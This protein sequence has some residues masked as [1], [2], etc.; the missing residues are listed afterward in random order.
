[1][2]SQRYDIVRK[3][4]GKLLLID[5]AADL[6]SAK[7]RIKE[8]TS[9]WPGEFQVLDQQNHRTIAKNTDP[10]EAPISDAKPTSNSRLSRQENFKRR[11]E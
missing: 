1:M 5:D 7:S 9:F 4:G 6:D 11:D 2:G 3:E 8:L 10:P